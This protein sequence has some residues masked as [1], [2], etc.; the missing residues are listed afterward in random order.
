MRTKKQVT[1][2]DKLRTALGVPLAVGMPGA[3][4]QGKDGKVA[5]LTS[6]F[7]APGKGMEPG[8]G[9]PGSQGPLILDEGGREKG[10]GMADGAESSDEGHAV[11]EA[12]VGRGVG[13]QQGLEGRVPVSALS[14]GDPQGRLVA[15]TTVDAGR[16]DGAEPI[17]L[18][19]PL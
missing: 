5:A 8:Q 6:G 9:S 12:G 15:M 4:I 11:N 14:P 10:L 13:Q 2:S 1:V 18:A 19:K 3:P 7:G 17:V 16:R